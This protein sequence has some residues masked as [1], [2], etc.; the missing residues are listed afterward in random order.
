MGTASD[1][2]IKGAWVIHHGRKLVLDVN[3]PAEF[4]AI[5]E[6]AKAATLLT[7]LGQT[8]QATVTKVE[9]RAIA[10]ASG[11]DPRL[12]LNGLLQVLERKRLIDQSKEDI[13]ILGVT[14]RGSLGHATD[15][16]NEAEPSTYEEAS[17]T[18]AEV[19]SEAPIRR[20]DVSQRIGDTHKLTNAQVDDFLDRAEGIGFVDKEGD[21]ND[22]LLFNGNLF[23][24]SSVAKTQK[25]LTSLDDAEQRL[26]SEISEQ[27]SK[28]GCLS[29][30]HVEQRSVEAAL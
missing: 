2:E 10:V 27:L 18:L 14:T 20:A 12:E 11:L 24:R 25:V 15:I 3:G 19:A 30:Q 8:N 1:R 21:G 17:I 6:A 28:S 4:P 9:A 7:K 13:S 23:R 5:N 16:Y 29:V 22:R 26:I